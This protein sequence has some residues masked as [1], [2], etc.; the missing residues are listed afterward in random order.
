MLQKL[1][2]SGAALPLVK[3][4][5]GMHRCLFDINTNIHNNI[6]IN[7][8]ININTNILQE[9]GGPR[10]PIGDPVPR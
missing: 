10:Q 6:D 7:T 9:K 4:A 3:E 1:A 8:T 5:E 2:H